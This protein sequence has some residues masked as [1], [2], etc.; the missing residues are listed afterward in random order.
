[1][2]KYDV[3]ITVCA[4]YIMKD[5]YPQIGVSM[6]IGRTTEL[7]LLEKAYASD[8]SELAVIYGRRRIGKSALVAQFLQGK[9][10]TFSFEALEDDNTSAQLS[11]F[12]RRL[13]KHM[14]EP[15]LEETEFKDWD[16][17]FDYFTRNVLVLKNDGTKYIIFLDE[18]QWM[19]VGKSALVGLLKYYWDNHWKQLHVV[20]ILCGSVSSFMIKDVLRSKALYGRTTLEINLKGLQPAEAYALLGKK[21]SVEEVLRYLLVF[22]AVPK[23]LE[24]IDVH[25][26]LNENMNSICFSKNGSMLS[27][28]D[29]IFHSQFRK[30]DTY[31]RIIKLL[32]GNLRSSKEISKT[33]EI[34]SGG[35]LTGYIDNLINAD[36]VIPY[37]PFGKE[38]GA[39][40]VKYAMSDEFL[41]FYLKY[42]KPN[43]RLIENSRSSKIFETVTRTGFDAWLGYAFERFCHKHAGSLA[44]IMGFA[45]EVI[46]VGP[47]F[48]KSDEKFQ[49]DLI[50]KRT[51]KIVVVCE[52][53]FSINEISTTVIPEIQ[54]KCALLKIPRGFTIQ[55]ALISL[56]GPDKALA[57]SRFF[58]HSVT[59]KDIF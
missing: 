37:V 47:L 4:L 16:R 44:Q 45:D 18:L 17:A 49:I 42:I 50:Y 28:A 21:R 19:A 15:L 55:K 3:V 1:M 9:L 54:R 27:E 36:L 22:G 38:Q 35:G 48:G 23:Y 29:K 58:D 7:E 51:D 10:H 43:I 57:D 40:S 14:S 46:Q 25:K 11:H 20:L 32:A 41:H 39:K 24:Q 34:K 53:K 26:S 33:A 31:F 2:R 13:A 8:K 12:T 6:F 56:Y 52:I 30:P 5:H 59:I